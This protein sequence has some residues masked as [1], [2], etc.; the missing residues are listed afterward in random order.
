MNKEHSGINI[1][2]DCIHRIMLFNFY[3]GKNL[4]RKSLIESFFF[5]CRHFLIMKKTGQWKIWENAKEIKKKKNQHSSFAKIKVNQNYFCSTPSSSSF[6]SF[7]FSFSL[8]LKNFQSIN[9]FFSFCNVE[10]WF[11]FEFFEFLKEKM[12]LIN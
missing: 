8:E 3:D 6:N 4:I 2:S 12:W 7:S 1:L 10:T 11:F 9:P 5:E